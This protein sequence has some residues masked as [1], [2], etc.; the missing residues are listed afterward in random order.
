[1]Y[2][3]LFYVVGEPQEDEPDHVTHAKFFNS[4]EEAKRCESEFSDGYGYVQTYKV[5]RV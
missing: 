5:E 4:L 1:M 2:M 3:C